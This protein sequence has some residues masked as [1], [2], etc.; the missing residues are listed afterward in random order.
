MGHTVHAN[1]WV[2]FGHLLGT[3]SGL[4]YVKLERLVH[5]SRKYWHD[6][7]H[8]KLQTP[9]VK[10][11]LGDVLHFDAG[12]SVYQNPL[13]IPAVLKAIYGARFMIHRPHP[14]F[15]L[16]PLEVAIMIAEI[17]C[18]VQHSVDD[19]DDMRN[20]LFA[21]QWKL[22]SWFWRARL[23]DDLFIEFAELKN[24]NK[25]VDWQMLR[26]ELMGLVLDRRW[27]IRN[28]LANRERIFGHIAEIKKIYLGLH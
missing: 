3:A 17:V 14:C 6:H 24:N 26:L 2:L 21:L 5:A 7:K 12:C 25:P 11:G 1:C 28:G 23:N 10:G 27:Y 22:F 9:L 20:L 8:W 13:I 18:P 19:V 15:S 4:G 16:V